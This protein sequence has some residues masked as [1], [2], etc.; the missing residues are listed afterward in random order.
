[1]ARKTPVD[2]LRRFALKFPDVQESDSCNRCAYKAGEKGFLYV[3]IKDDAYNALIK[4]GKKSSVEAAKLEK[5]KPENYTIGKTGW[6]T[7]NFPNDEA[8]PKGL[9]ERWVGESYRAQVPRKKKA[10]R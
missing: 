6:V 4:L 5:K 9:L 8:P 10:T 2:S 1:M 3:G 7:I